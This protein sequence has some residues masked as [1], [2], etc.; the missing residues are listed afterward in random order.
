MPES[1]PPSLPRYRRW[2]HSC[3]GSAGC[4]D[5][6]LAAALSTSSSMLPQTILLVFVERRPRMLA[7]MRVL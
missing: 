1:H 5:T 2:D 7:A 3:S 6:L 4:G